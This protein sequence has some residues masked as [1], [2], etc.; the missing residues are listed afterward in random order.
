MKWKASLNKAFAEMR[1][2][3]IRAK[4]D[5]TCCQTCGNYEIEEFIRKQDHGYAFYH[6]QD[7][8]SMSRGFVYLCYG[9]AHDNDNPEAVGR[10][11]CDI[12]RSFGFRVIWDGSIKTRIRVVLEG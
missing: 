2:Q 6:A 10:Q 12:L 7:T 1:R 4:Q 8:D 5:F 9:G 11:I 3:G